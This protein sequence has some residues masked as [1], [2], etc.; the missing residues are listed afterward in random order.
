[1]VWEIKNF[2]VGEKSFK[3]KMIF[4]TERTLYQIRK[5]TG[6]IHMTFEINKAKNPVLSIKNLTIEGTTKDK[7]GK[8]VRYI[9]TSKSYIIRV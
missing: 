1:M 8:W 9:T 6:P 4:S 2:K 3:T 7:P 5:E